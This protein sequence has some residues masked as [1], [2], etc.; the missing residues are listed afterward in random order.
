MASS[1]TSSPWARSLTLAVLA[2]GLASACTTRDVE[3][4]VVDALGEAA[5]ARMGDSSDTDRAMDFIRIPIE[6]REI[7]PHIFQA[8]GV[9]NT[10]LIVTR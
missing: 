5:A 4:R 8:R 2:L 10:N 6:A 3:L 7:R 9:A 1:M